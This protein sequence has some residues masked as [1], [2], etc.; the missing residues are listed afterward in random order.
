MARYSVLTMLLTVPRPV[1]VA[2]VDT[3][4]E[5]VRIAR[6]LKQKGN[7]RIQIGDGQ[8][9]QYFPVDEFAAK[10]GIR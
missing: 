1:A 3:P 10:H 9:E 2:Q 7:D 6:E 4:A 8:L 5:A